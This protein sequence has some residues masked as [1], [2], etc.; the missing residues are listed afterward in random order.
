MKQINYL[1][2]FFLLPFCSLKAQTPDE[3]K[4]W[5]PPCRRLDCLR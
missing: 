2:L 4:S 1:L 5:L 3:L